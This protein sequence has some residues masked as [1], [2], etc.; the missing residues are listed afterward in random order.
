MV[1]TSRRIRRSLSPVT[2]AVTIVVLTVVV[3]L[4]TTLVATLGLSSPVQ[5]IEPNQMIRFY[6]INKKDQADR[7]QFTASKAR[8]PG[9]HNFIKKARVHRVVQIGYTSCQLYSSKNCAAD[10][11]IPA[12]RAKQSDQQKTELAQG[13]SWFPVDENKRGA[14]LKSWYCE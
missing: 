11:A 14:R 6:K 12:V 2:T 13:Y 3:T 7:I 8:K 4:V 9:C 5:A 10:T 1:S